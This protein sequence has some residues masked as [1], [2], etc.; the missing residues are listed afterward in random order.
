MVIKFHQILQRVANNK[1]KRS[2][3]CLDQNG[4]DLHIEDTSP[5]IPHATQCPPPLQWQDDKV[6]KWGGGLPMLFFSS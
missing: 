2:L 5:G 3:L 1:Y 4:E 6:G